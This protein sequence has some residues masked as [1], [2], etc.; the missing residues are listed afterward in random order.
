MSLRRARVDAVAC[1]HF[2]NADRAG[3]GAARL[4]AGDV[5][6]VPHGQ[7]GQQQVTHARLRGGLAGAFAGQVNTAQSVVATLLVGCLA[8]EQVSAACSLDQTL[9]QVGIARVREHGVAL[10]V[11][12]GDAQRV[13]VLRGVNHAERLHAEGTNLHGLAL[14]PGVVLKL[15][16]HARLRVQAVSRRKV[17]VNRGGTVQRNAALGPAARI[18]LDRHVQTGQVD[19]VVR[20]QVRNQNRV[21]ITQVDMALEHAE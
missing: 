13:R 10:A 14:S 16:A 5:R 21:D 20:V 7:V 8:E 2:G 9:A 17:L 4:R 11:V 6:V 18:P 1:R 15:G 19:A 12:A 3:E